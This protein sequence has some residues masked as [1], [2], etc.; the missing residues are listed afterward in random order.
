MNNYCPSVLPSH[1]YYHTVGGRLSNGLDS[2]VAS[3]YLHSG[4][5]WAGNKI[6]GEFL[7]RS[8]S[9]LM[10]SG[11]V[12][13]DSGAWQAITPFRSGRKGIDGLFIKFNEQGL[14]HD[15]LVSEAK[16]GS[17]KLGLT[18]DGL[19]MSTAWCRRRLLES[20]EQY[21]RLA[22][23]LKLGPC[24]WGGRSVGGRSIEV[25]QRDGGI[26]ALRRSR[27]GIV[28]ADGDSNATRAGLQKQARAI[29]R[30]LRA[31][32]E[33]KISYR[34][35]VIR[36]EGR[37]GDWKMTIERLDSAS[38]TVTFRTTFKGNLPKEARTLLQGTL[39]SKLKEDGI[40]TGTAREIAKRVSQDTSLLSNVQ[41]AQKGLW[42]V[43]LDL[44]M[45]KTAGGAAIFAML[46][47]A[48]RSL[49]HGDEF[50][51]KH[52]ARIGVAAGGGAAIGYYASSQVQTRLLTT[53]VGRKILGLLPV[54]GASGSSVAGAAGLVS[55]VAASAAF[56]LIGWA[57]GMLSPK[58]ARVT[59][60]AGLV[61]AAGSL[62]FTTGVLGAAMAWG[63]AGTGV[64]IS[65]LSGAA[66]TNAGLA[67]LG[68]GTV[69]AGGGGIVVGT[70]VLTGGGA[71]V[72]ILLA[73]A[74][75]LV[76]SKLDE[77]ERKTLAVR[78]LNI[79]EGSIQNK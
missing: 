73:S 7:E 41:T 27:D 14:P 60:A 23:D 77:Y 13:A 51:F 6:K 40:P 66:A 16:Y 9:G 32:G 31:A 33:G 35:R 70:A 64:A 74:V 67:V 10:K 43:G 58:E 69:A 5:F 11:I 26:I 28:I 8:I 42:K 59:A 38:G 61:G 34:P 2:Q 39:E 17:S 45:L 37:S 63:T 76:R 79:V 24:R 54:R 56:A 55:G 36:L 65:T 71:V 25:P 19:Q 3:T 47:E 48:G 4:P 12:E 68:G 29:A 30:I 57:T 15:I 21:A 1:L 72:G 50:N 46:V 49:W 53:A 20:S 62:A 44:G 52:I 22:D 75:M 78:Q 18:K